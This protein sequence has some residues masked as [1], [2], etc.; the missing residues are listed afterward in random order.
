M[1]KVLKALFTYES[2]QRRRRTKYCNEEGNTANDQSLHFI[3]DL[4]C[5]NGAGSPGHIFTSF[6]I[7][8]CTWILI[9]LSTKF[10]NFCMYFSQKTILFRGRGIKFVYKIKRRC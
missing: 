1:Q 4:L 9:V 10:E 2:R 5:Y 8:E 3:L 6:Q 7:L